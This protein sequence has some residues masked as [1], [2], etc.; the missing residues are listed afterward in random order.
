MGIVAKI[1]STKYVCNTLFLLYVF[2]MSASLNLGF[3]DTAMVAQATTVIISGIT[4]HYAWNRISDVPPLQE[5]SEKESLI[6]CGFRKMNE[7]CAEVRAKNRPLMY[8]LLSTVFTNPVFASYLIVGPTFGKEYLGFNS[9][10][11]ALAIVITYAAAAPGA[12]LSKYLAKKTNTL[13]SLRFFSILVFFNA[14]FCAVFVTGSNVKALG[15][16]FFTMFGLCLGGYYSAEIAL[17]AS[18]IPYEQE[19]HFT[20]TY[21]FA[22]RVC[23]WLPPL[24]YTALN[25]NGF[26]KLT[27]KSILKHL[28][29]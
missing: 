21:A 4:M 15:Y 8:I 7:T 18:I 6:S 14:C 23:I 16:T 9:T 12:M 10:E 20:G 27:L 25:E 22:I 11:S 29:F 1:D 19:A 24:L 2:I 26:G 28:Y 3:V 5:K 17:V 13:W